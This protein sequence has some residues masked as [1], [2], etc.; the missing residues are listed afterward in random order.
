[1]FLDTSPLLLPL[2]RLRDDNEDYGLLQLDP[3]AAVVCHP[4]GL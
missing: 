4:S 2:A 3:G 1:M